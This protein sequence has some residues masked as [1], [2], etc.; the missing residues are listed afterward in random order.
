MEWLDDS[1][2]PTQ[3]LSTVEDDIENIV[4]ETATR[5]G[6]APLGTVRESL[7]TRLPIEDSVLASLLMDIRRKKSDENK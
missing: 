7:K 6:L 2:S 5:H 1:G 3:E 4:E